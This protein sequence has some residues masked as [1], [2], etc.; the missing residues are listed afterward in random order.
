MDIIV[1]SCFLGA[2]FLGLWDVIRSSLGLEPWNAAFYALLIASLTIN[3]V[4]GRNYLL[5][6]NDTKLTE[7]EA[8]RG[9][10]VIGSDA[11]KQLIDADTQDQQTPDA[12]SPVDELSIA[13]IASKQSSNGAGADSQIAVIASNG[14]SSI[15]TEQP[16]SAGIGEQHTSCTVTAINHSTAEE[17]A[18]DQSSSITASLK[19]SVAAQTQNRY[20]D[21]EICHKI[22]RGATYS[23]EESLGTNRLAFT[24]SRGIPNQRLARAFG[25]DNGFTT[26]DDDYGR[27]FRSEAQNRL[28]LATKEGWGPIAGKA[29]AMASNYAKK[30]TGHRRHSLDQLVQII[31]LKLVFE[32]LL[33]LH[34]GNLGDDDVLRIA[35]HINRLWIESKSSTGSD[36]VGVEQ[37]RPYFETLGIR[38]TN[39]GDNPLNL[40]LPAYETLWRVVGRCLIEV[41]FRPSADTEWL[42]VLKEFLKR[43]D[44]I[45]TFQRE[46][47][48]RK[49]PVLFLVK[50]ALRLYPP[51]RRIYRAFHMTSKDEPEVVAA[52]IEACHRLTTIWGDDSD[53]YQPT[54]WFSANAAMNRAFMPFGGSPYICP[55]SSS[56]APRMIGVLVAAIA[57]SI[58]VTDWKLELSGPTCSSFTLLSDETELG[59][60]RT[61]RNE[62]FLVR[63]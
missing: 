14:E 16:S 25:I 30:I 7:T 10:Q 55:A 6:D 37:F 18:T 17:P 23:P 60:D 56:F 39:P 29:L 46:A 20:S 43:P 33:G 62:W 12:E 41:V 45:K 26:F 21:P 5:G 59:S 15:A 51:T 31:S 38:Q 22:L 50:E 44:D 52:D 28:S 49:V 9:Q 34:S 40:L 36:A 57:S 58:S 61:E 4:F 3:A 19:G 8:V 27:A 53:K 11:T 2:L 35:E 13:E 63:K 1:G 48:G 24:V 32:A 42:D 47:G 54:R